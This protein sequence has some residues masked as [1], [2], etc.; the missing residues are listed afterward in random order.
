MIVLNQPSSQ[1]QGSWVDLW[2]RASW[3]TSLCSR[4]TAATCNSFFIWPI[5]FCVISGMQPKWPIS[6]IMEKVT[7]RAL[8][9]H[10]E[11]AINALRIGNDVF[12]WTKTG[13][14][15][16]LIYE[17][18]PLVYGETG[19]TTILA[20]LNSIITEQRL[21]QLGCRA[22]YITAESDRLLWMAITRFFLAPPKL[23]LAIRSGERHWKQDCFPGNIIWLWLTNHI[24]FY[25]G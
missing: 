23:R 5:R 9:S 20:P 4:L 21:Q 12:V 2:P 6:K 1:R 25:S 3:Q 22:T 17:C 19:V 16:S 14:G 24:L 7:I 13:S 8:N 15:K 11:R 10:Q 18:A